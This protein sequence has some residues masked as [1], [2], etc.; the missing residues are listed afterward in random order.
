MFISLGLRRLRQ[1]DLELRPTYWESIKKTKQNPNNQYQTNKVHSFI[2]FKETQTRVLSRL[3]RGNGIQI[4]LGLWGR[5]WRLERVGEGWDLLPEA[6]NDSRDWWIPQW[7]KSWLCLVYRKEIC[8]QKSWRFPR[9]GNGGDTETSLWKEG[10]ASHGKLKNLYLMSYF[11][12]SDS[13]GRREAWAGIL[14]I[15]TGVLST[16]FLS[17]QIP[18]VLVCCPPCLL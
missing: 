10:K 6:I 2:E 5:L 8:F 9:R 18:P 12:A 14:G 1:K 11:S 7:R 13:V 15:C 17:F 4:R 16:C 3:C